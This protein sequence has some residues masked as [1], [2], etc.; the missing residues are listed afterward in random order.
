M[1]NK[2]PVFVVQP[3]LR[4]YLIKSSLTFFSAFCPLPLPPPNSVVEFCAVFSL[5]KSRILLFC[6]ASPKRVVS[7]R[8]EQSSEMRAPSDSRFCAPNDS[9]EAV[10]SGKSSIT[11]AISRQ[12]SKTALQQRMSPRAWH[13]LSRSAT[14][15]LSSSNRTPLRM[16]STITESDIL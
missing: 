6:R 5:T 3:I 13:S 14:V 15:A 8:L 9:D 12:Q 7:Q 16:T 1:A 4:F 10:S 2:S 11:F